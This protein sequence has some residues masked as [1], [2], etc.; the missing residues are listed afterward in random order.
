MT[1]L[2]QHAGC[3]L[4]RQGT[5]QQRNVKTFMIGILKYI[6]LTHQ[7]NWVEIVDEHPIAVQILLFL[8]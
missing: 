7:S 2:V 8:S 6:S 3:N 5:I 1:I 4:R